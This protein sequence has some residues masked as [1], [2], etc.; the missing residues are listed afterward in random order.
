MS[1]SQRAA[2]ETQSGPPAA[3]ASLKETTHTSQAV[4]LQQDGLQQLRH[5]QRPKRPGAHA[6]NRL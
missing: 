2:T 6:G 4:F 3:A 1:I 5:E